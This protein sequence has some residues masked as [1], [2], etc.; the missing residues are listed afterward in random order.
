VNTGADCRLTAIS[1]AQ[2]VG[3]WPADGVDTRF[4]LPDGHV[5]L[6]CFNEGAGPIGGTRDMSHVIFTEHDVANTDYWPGPAVE[7]EGTGPICGDGIVEG[8]EQCDDGG[9]LI[10]AL[11]TTTRN[12]VVAASNTNPLILTMPGNGFSSFTLPTFSGMAGGTWSTL[13]GQPGYTF[14]EASDELW[15]TDGLVG[16][17]PDSATNAVEVEFTS[18]DPHGYTTG[19]AVMTSLFG[20]GWIPLNNK[21]WIATV[22]GANTFTIPADTTTYGPMEGGAIWP[23]LDGTA[24]GTYTPSSGSYSPVS[25]EILT[26]TPSI[27]ISPAIP[28]GTPIGYSGLRFTFSP[29]GSKF[30]AIEEINGSTSW[31][32]W[33]DGGTLVYDIKNASEY[34]EAGSGYITGSGYLT[35]ANDGCSEICLIE[36]GPGVEAQHQHRAGG[37]F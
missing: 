18:P 7:V 5:A 12:D 2:V 27:A 13:N 14:P 8:L 23:L 24:L 19:D 20:G 6:N 4:G 34:G 16:V 21:A 1:Y 35:V 33:Q 26:V 37:S 15:I 9:H 32:Y 10:S 3:E 30:P 28:V 22:T 17:D 29:A 31:A 36:P 11:G 25:P